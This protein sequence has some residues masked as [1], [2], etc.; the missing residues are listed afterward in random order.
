MIVIVAVWPVDGII[1]PFGSERVAEKVSAFSTIGSLTMDTDINW[2]NEFPG[3]NDT[4][5]FM[6]PKSPAVALFA[7]VLILY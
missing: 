7:T 5:W 4:I 3:L 1:T 2:R 6:L